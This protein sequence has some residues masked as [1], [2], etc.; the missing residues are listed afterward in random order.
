[1]TAV[2]ERVRRPE[3][4]AA[5]IEAALLLSL[6]LTPLMLGVLYYG[7]F[8]WKLQRVPELDPNI[9]QSG[10]VGTFC[11]NQQTDLLTR[12]RAAALVSAQNLDNGTDL[13]VSLSDITATVVQYTP[14]ALGVVVKV[15]FRTHVL[16][17]AVSWLP[18]PNDGNVVSD[19]QVRLENVVITSGSC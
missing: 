9:D 14:G 4:G 6:V 8:F 11:L 2:R 19:S 5:A 3:R 16:D 1:M 12:V 15:G 13:P 18:L 7:F 10:I 17:E